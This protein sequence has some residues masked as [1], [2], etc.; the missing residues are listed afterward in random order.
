MNRSGNA[1]SSRAA[2]IWLTTQKGRRKPFIVWNVQKVTWAEPPSAPSVGPSQL[3][4]LFMRGKR[5]CED[6]HYNVLCNYCNAH[7]LFTTLI[8]STIFWEIQNRSSYV[9]GLSLSFHM[10]ENKSWKS[11]F[12]LDLTG[13]GHKVKPQRYVTF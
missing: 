7:R 1:A 8:T 13:L 5:I 4:E 9:R 12:I 2:E 11:I 3:S 10:S 6:T